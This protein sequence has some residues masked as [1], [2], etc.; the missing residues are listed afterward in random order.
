MNGADLAVLVV[1]FLDGSSNRV[2]A[3]TDLEGLVWFV[4]SSVTPYHMTT[5]KRPNSRPIVVIKHPTRLKIVSP[6]ITFGRLES[7]PTFMYMC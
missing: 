2:E 6:K 4:G 3:G 1:Q 7:S 5:R